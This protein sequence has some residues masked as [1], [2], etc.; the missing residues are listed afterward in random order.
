MNPGWALPE[1][2]F[3]WIEEN[4]PFGSN[5][6]ELGSGHGSLRLSKNYQ[7]WSIE[8]DEAWLNISSNTYIHAEITPFS[9]NGKKGQ[10]YN[11][12]KIKNTLPSEYALLIIDGPPN[13]IGRSGILSHLDIFNWN[14]HVLVDDTHRPNDQKIAY[15]L[16]SQ[17][18]LNKIHFT[19]HYEQTD[20]QRE[21][22]ILSPKKVMI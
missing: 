20:T 14:C 1:K 5:I 13:S 9:V 2:A 7:L 19:E 6:V 8:H 12:E 10:W 11:S 18:S 17:K 16:A 4:I 3:Q 21:F 22:V 15:E